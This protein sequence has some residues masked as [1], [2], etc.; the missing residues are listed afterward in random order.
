MNKWIKGS[1]TRVLKKRQM[2]ERAII[3]FMTIGYL[4]NKLRNLYF[5]AVKKT[6]SRWVVVWPLST[7]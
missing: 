7:K 1:K 3:H 5:L 2:R 4:P 6:G